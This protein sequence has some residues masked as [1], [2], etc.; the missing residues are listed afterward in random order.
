MSD[1]WNN[2]KETATQTISKVKNWTTTAVVSNLEKSK[3]AQYQFKKG[4]TADAGSKDNPYALTSSYPLYKTEK[5]SIKASLGRQHT[6]YFKPLFTSKIEYILCKAGEYLEE[7]LVGYI[8][9]IEDK[10]WFFA[11]L[12]QT[13]NVSITYEAKS[14]SQ[15][16]LKFVY[17]SKEEYFPDTINLDTILATIKS[18]YGVGALADTSN[19]TITLVLHKTNA[20]YIEAEKATADYTEEQSAIKKQLDT[21]IKQHTDI[22]S[23]IG[24][25]AVADKIKKLNTDI[26][27]AEGGRFSDMMK[28]ANIIELPTEETKK[29]VLTE[30]LNTVRKPVTQISVEALPPTSVMR[31]NLSASDLNKGGNIQEPYYDKR[32]GNA[33]D[34][35]IYGIESKINSPGCIK[36]YKAAMSSGYE[37]PITIDCFLLQSVQ[38]ALKEKFSVFQSLSGDTLAYFFGKQPTMYR[39]SA[40][41]YNTYNQDWYNDFK[42]YYE[43]NLRGSASI[44]RN[45][46]TVISYENRVIEG[47]FIEMN[48]QESATNTNTINIDF[49]ILHIQD[50]VLNYD[51]PTV[52]T[53][54][55]GDVITYE[56]FEKGALNIGQQLLSQIP[57]G[58]STTLSYMLPGAETALI[59]LTGSRDTLNTLGDIFNNAVEQT[60]LKSDIN[61][62]S[63]EYQSFEKLI[64]YASGASY[65]KNAEMLAD[66]KGGKL[67]KAQFI[68]LFGPIAKENERQTGIPAAVTMAQAILETGWGS[69]SIG[70]AKNLFGIKGTGPAGTTLHWTTE[71]KNGMKYRVQDYFRKYNSWQE[72]IEDHSNF[73]LTNKRYSS[74]IKSYNSGKA[75]G[76]PVQ[77]NVD[78]FARGIHDAGYATDSKY[79]DKLISI[80]KSNNL[81]KWSAR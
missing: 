67:G 18:K 15:S 5:V 30:A 77:E 1:F 11:N 61:H 36:L 6:L 56:D 66:Y 75:F 46:R 9:K 34:N 55:Q 40:A 58:F 71:E 54:R 48:A 53:G 72:S 21:V 16:I 29:T 25:D 41:L 38:L 68:N 37:E 70:D 27:P 2:L 28:K 33:K 76:T 65:Q 60:K 35:D 52:Y 7:S 57:S 73:L 64:E 26:L 3:V 13:I 20:K 59:D 19:Q 47:F 44:S 50:T 8:K 42:F 63:P 79:S 80:M 49:T 10:V 78:A 12:T 4:L 23:G 17:G 69:S 45:V 39:F 81:Y 32:P 14:E 62:N 31:E 51:P 43:N 74:A 24:N 22:L